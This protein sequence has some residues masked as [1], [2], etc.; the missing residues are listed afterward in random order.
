[1][2]KDNVVTYVANYRQ[3][4]GFFRTWVIMAKNIYKSRD[5]VWQLFKKD[6]TAAYKKSFIGL[7]WVLISPIIG[8][9]S[10]VL[11]NYAGVLKPGDVGIPYPAFV[12]L[13]SSLW[14]LFMGFYS[15]AS[16]TLGAGGGFI[17][18]VKYPHEA[19]L[20]KQTAQHLAN[21]SITFVINVIVLILFGVTPSAAIVL[22]PIFALPLFF[23]GAGMGLIASVVSVVAS[24][25]TNIFNIILGFLFYAT[26]IV[27][28]VNTLENETLRRIIELNPLTYLVGGLRDLILYGT[29]NNIDR[30]LIYTLIS[31][32]FFM[33]SW[34]LF[35]VSEDKVIEKIL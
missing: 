1:M 33:F 26:P 14:G 23:L 18:Q 35:F 20:L 32:L 2:Y 30:F 31:F 27:Y 13:G 12:L 17:L 15:S 6:F 19:L 9:V 29:I 3:K 11:L 24:D 28:S 10:W 34:R 25:V 8:I 16:G 5:L 22:T 4:I 7:S 21:F